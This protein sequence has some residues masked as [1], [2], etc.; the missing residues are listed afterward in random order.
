M[1]H[2]L[3]DETA[4]QIAV[5]ARRLYQ[6]PSSVAYICHNYGSD[7]W[8][9]FEDLAYDVVCGADNEFMDAIRARWT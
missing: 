9:K 7:F 8:S 4:I 1:D 5:L 6:E 3:S 2:H